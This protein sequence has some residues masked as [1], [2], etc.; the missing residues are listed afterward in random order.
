MQLSQ[1]HI[2]CQSSSRHHSADGDPGPEEGGH[3]EHPR[4]D[5][6]RCRAATIAG[7]VIA[8]VCAVAVLVALVTVAEAGVDL[9]LQIKHVG[10]RMVDNKSTPATGGAVVT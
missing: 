10:L 8:L 5:L 2:S 3:G 1:Y 6:P 7:H 9:V 4:P